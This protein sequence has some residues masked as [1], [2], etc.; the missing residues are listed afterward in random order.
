MRI[1]EIKTYFARLGI[2]FEQVDGMDIAEK[3]PLF[4]TSSY[5]LSL[6]MVGGECIVLMFSK[7]HGL[8]PH[9]IASQLQIV[10]DTM[11]LRPV[12]VF[13]SLDKELYAFLVNGGI[14]FI[15]PRKGV[16]I[17]PRISLLSDTIPTEPVA[18]RSKL[19]VSAQLMVLWHLNFN[20]ENRELPFKSVITALKM[21]KVYVSRSAAEIEA[22]NLALITRNGC[23][24]S[25]LFDCNAQNLW[26][27]VH[28]LM[29][30]PV[31]RTV[32]LPSAPNDALLAGISALSEYSSI[33]DDSEQT[34]AVPRCAWHI[35]DAI[36]SRYNG[37]H[38]QKWWYDP[39]LLSPDG[40][41]VDKL[42]LYL[43]LK[44]DPDPRV[45]GCLE[46][47]LEEMKW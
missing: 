8:S 34:F 43:A 47:M 24:K 9:D 2:D 3:L 40:R 31:Q 13:M 5:D 4:V 21:N 41:K 25:L 6:C 22:F 35:D 17:P 10:A 18:I 14:S 15:V 16:F 19:S 46:E 32:R 33:N 20:N 23:S 11:K 27:K 37:V 42:S 30:S 1:L 44:D 45:Q 29:R 26:R 39:A 28:P 7:R 38:V 12:L 36:V